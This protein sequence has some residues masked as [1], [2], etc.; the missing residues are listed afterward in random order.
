MYFSGVT[1]GRPHCIS[2]RPL[3]LPVF[4]AG[5]VYSLL[6]AFRLD[7]F[8]PANFLDL[9][10]VPMSA[11]PVSLLTT[12]TASHRLWNHAATSLSFGEL[13]NLLY[14]SFLICREPGPLSSLPSFLGL[15]VSEFRVLGT[16]K[17]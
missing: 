16:L 5:H 4:L 12:E 7:S 17:R 14:L 15:D 10:F 2:D 9:R 8:P 13:S 6:A 11:S 3:F 1:Q